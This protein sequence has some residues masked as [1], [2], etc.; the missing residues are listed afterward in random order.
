MAAWDGVITFSMAAVCDIMRLAIGP[1]SVDL[2]TLGGGWYTVCGT[3][4]LVCC[5]TGS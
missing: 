5:D 4:D 1:M 2:I 3:L